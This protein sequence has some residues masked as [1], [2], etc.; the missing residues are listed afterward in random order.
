MT[1]VPAMND[2]SYLGHIELGTPKMEESLWFFT[3]MMGMAETAREGQSVYLRCWGDVDRTTLKLTES[4][5]AGLLHTGW[6]TNGPDALERRVASLEASGRG[7][8]W[9]EGDVGHG[10]AYRFTDPDEHL[11]EVYWDVERYQC[12][13]ADRS[14]YKN[15]PQRLSN[16]GAMVR[17]L[18][19]LHVL[20]ND[21]P[22][23]RGF[24][25]E[26]LGFKL[27]E[28]VV[29]D[30]GTELSS[31]NSVTPLVHDIAYSL[32]GAVGAKGRLHHAGWL[33]ENREDILRAADIFSDNGI[34]LE[35]GPSRHK[36]S[37]QFFL[38]LYEPGGNRIELVTGGYL[39]FHPDW[40]PITWSEAD[41]KHGQAWGL[42]LPPSFHSYGTPV[43]DADAYEH[44]DITV[45]GLT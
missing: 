30:D 8:G 20:C 24:M 17:R 5:D 27:R 22:L 4:R 11:M 37:H 23:N 6:R 44:R 7:I 16:R 19:H 31:W 12:S 43:V 25:S 38:Y 32:D 26:Q 15:T 9:V 36:I 33:L 28:N 45:V 42:H 2:V 14:H 35:S 39:I 10:A 41:R 1:F 29:L 13:D 18:D 21:V 3:E 40:E 34:F